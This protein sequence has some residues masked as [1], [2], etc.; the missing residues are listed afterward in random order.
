STAAAP[1]PIHVPD[2]GDFDAVEVIEV[3][4]SA[5]DTVEAEQTLITLE[6]DKATLEVPAPE[7]G[8]IAAVQVAEGDQVS[9]GDVIAALVGGEQKQAATGTTTDT[10][11]PDQ[12]Q[13]APGAA[14]TE[15]SAPQREASAP[16]AGKR[17]PQRRQ[18]PAG[19][20][21][22]PVDEKAFAKAHASPAVRKYARQLG[23]DLGRITG[24]GRKQRILFEDV[25]AYVKDLV[26]QVEQGAAGAG[27]PGQPDIDF[28]RYG[29]VET[30]GL[31]RIRKLSARAVHDNWLLIPHVTQ[32]DE[33]DITDMEAFRQAE[34]ARAAEQ[35]VKLTPVAFLLKASAA[36]LQAFPDLNS[37]LSADGEHLIHKKYCHIAVA[38]D[39]EAGLV[40]PV[41]RDVDRKGIFQL[42][43]ELGEISSRARAG[44]L[45]PNEMQGACFSISS[46]GG[47]GGTAFT[48]IVNSPEV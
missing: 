34:K 9:Q 46:L 7:G 44:K 39:T 6:S 29:E 2:I 24:T 20:G 4:I 16:S 42:A 5:G 13:T 30:V 33:A 17:S 12:Q 1:R 18:T 41:V 43:E 37:S 28:S 3:L 10:Q 27:L 47:V 45:K 25:N 36:A 26:Q 15:Q 38:V 21:L 23:V 48:P 19:S 32:F 11:Q 22:T 8:E 31:S 40:M 35:G 14:D